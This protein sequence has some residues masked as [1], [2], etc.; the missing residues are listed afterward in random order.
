MDLSE[1]ISDLAAAIVAVDR[2]GQPFR[3][4]QPGVGPYGEPQLVK[5]LA[6]KLNQSPK[7]HGAAR[8]MRTPDLLIP[9]AWAL[10][11]KIT[12][13]FGDNGK[14]AENWSVNLL[15][16]YPGNVSAVGDCFKLKN[17]TGPE[18]KGIV[19]IGYEH[20]PPRIDLKPLVECFEL[21]AGQ[22]MGF[23]LSERIERS[24]SGL[25]HPIHQSLRLFAWELMNDSA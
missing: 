9:E 5:L 13:P 14:E 2:C 11:F 17:Y 8:T 23:R 6:S 21:I 1:V 12:R 15:H 4:F 24:H 10:E 18:R 3:N 7:Y 20:V 25:V 16:P 22:I 19:V